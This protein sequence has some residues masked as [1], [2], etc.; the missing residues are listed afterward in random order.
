M[1]KDCQR[2]MRFQ[3]PR[4]VP[5]G[6][7]AP[8]S[9]ETEW[10]CKKGWPGGHGVAAPK[11]IMAPLST[12]AEGPCGKGCPRRRGISA[13]KGV[14]ARLSREAE[15]PR[16][17]GWQRGHW[18]SAL[19]GGTQGRDGPTKYGGRGAMRERMSKGPMGFSAQGRCPRVVPKGMMTQ[20]SMEDEEPCRKGSSRAHGV[21]APK[22]GAQG[23]DGL[24]KFGGRGA[25]RKRMAKGPQ[26][27]SAQGHD[28]PTKYGG[29]GA[30]WKRMA[31]GPWGFNAQGWCPTRDG[32]TKDGGRGAIR[33][34]MAKGPWGF[35]AQG[36]C[37]RA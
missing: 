26:D 37:P 14:M 28:G 18:V 17:K 19:K 8:L 31:N 25:M 13:P 10:P 23:R 3:R 34:R 22:G 1:E 21:S 29:Q 16:G 35:N 7:M 30:M 2:A 36:Q 11:G 32:P 27:F 20:L 4:V 6:V 15:R 33:K 5:K 24:T 12:E 9:T